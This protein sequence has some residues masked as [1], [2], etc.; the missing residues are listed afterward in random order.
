MV[1]LKPSKNNPPSWERF[2]DAHAK[3]N[4]PENVIRNRLALN[5]HRVQK[6]DNQA[7]ISEVSPTAVAIEDYMSFAQNGD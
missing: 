5:Q 3:A 2:L 7:F 4:I 1:R 6:H